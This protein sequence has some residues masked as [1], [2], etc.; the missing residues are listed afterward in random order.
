VP[1]LAGLLGGLAAPAHASTFI[2][3]SRTIDSSNSITGDVFVSGSGTVVTIASGG[4]ISGGVDAE[5]GTTVN[6]AGGSAT[7]APAAR[8]SP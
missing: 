7:R 1:L 6:I 4:S 2:T 5:S 3:S 8:R